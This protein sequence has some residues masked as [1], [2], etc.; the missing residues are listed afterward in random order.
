MKNRRNK[1]S[2]VGI[3]VVFLF[4]LSTLGYSADEPAKDLLVGSWE[5]SGGDY[6]LTFTETMYSV[7]DNSSECT[8]VWNY[9]VSGDSLYSAFVLTSEPNTCVSTEKSNTVSFSVSEDTLTFTYGPN[10]SDTYIRTSSTQTGG[11]TNSS[12]SS[13]N[14]GIECFINTLLK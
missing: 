7:H 8:F 13:S 11:A 10:E 5:S 3:I 12:S 6:S 2:I 14:T 1:L 4:G 9:S